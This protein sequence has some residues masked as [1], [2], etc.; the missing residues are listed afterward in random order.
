ME[1]NASRLRPSGR[2]RE[3]LN[4]ERGNTMNDQEIREA[5]KDV[6][7]QYDRFRALW[8]QK[9]DNV[10]GFDDWFRTQTVFK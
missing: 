7:R 10:E 6:M 9:Y 8:F 1:F 2:S 4:I 3:P 5:V